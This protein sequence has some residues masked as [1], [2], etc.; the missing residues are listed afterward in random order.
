[1]ATDRI[2]ASIVTPTAVLQAGKRDKVDDPSSSELS[3]LISG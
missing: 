2:A 1:M 3:S